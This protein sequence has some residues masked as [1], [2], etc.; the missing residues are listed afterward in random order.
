[1]KTLTDVTSD[2]ARLVDGGRARIPTVQTK[3]GPVDPIAEWMTRPVFA[4]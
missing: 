2:E 1:M 3:D 4:E